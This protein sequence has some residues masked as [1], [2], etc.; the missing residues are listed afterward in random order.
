MQ[1]RAGDG[2]TLEVAHEDHPV[3][4]FGVALSPVVDEPDQV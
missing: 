1:H 2:V 4:Q 3:V